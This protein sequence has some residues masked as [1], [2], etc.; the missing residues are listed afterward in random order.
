MTSLL[1]LDSPAQTRRRFIGNILDVVGQSNTRVLY[2]PDYAEGLTV[3]DGAVQTRVWTH[4]ATPTGRLS[5]LGKGYAL[6]FNGSSDYL[7][8]PDAADLSFGDGSVDTAMGMF[9]VINVTDT[10]NGRNLITKW[11]AGSTAREWAWQLSTTDVIRFTVRDESAG[12]SPVR[13]TD[14]ATTQGSWAMPGLTYSG[15]GGG[16]AMAGVTHYLNGAEVAS[17]ASEQAAYVAMENTNSVVEIGAIN[18]HTAAFLEGKLAL[19]VVWLG[20]TAAQQAGL[21]SLSRSFFVLS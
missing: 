15:V 21:T 17:T 4:G 12:V 6:A 14:A 10:A 11:V 13:D 1:F 16:T 19:I 9:A 7:S 18:A 8:T 20:G 2:T 5:A 3:V